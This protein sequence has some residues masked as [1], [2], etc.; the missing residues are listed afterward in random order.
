MNCV[1][2]SK[3]IWVLF[4]NLVILAF[5]KWPNF[6]ILVF[7]VAILIAYL[8]QNAG[9]LYS[10]ICPKPFGDFGDFILFW[11]FFGIWA[12]AANFGQNVKKLDF[13]ETVKG[14]GIKPKGDF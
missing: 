10:V 6:D 3:K 11:T 1:L 8:H 13:T 12:K 14:N 9:L 7:S 2:S 4:A 5:S